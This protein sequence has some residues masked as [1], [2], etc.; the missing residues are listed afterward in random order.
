MNSSNNNKL[1]FILSLA[2][3]FMVTFAFANDRLFYMFCEAVG[4]SVS[5]NNETA[6]IK[7]EDIDESHF[8]KVLFTTETMRDVRVDFGV[9]KRSI[10]INLGKVYDNEYHFKNLTGDTL[11]FRPIHSVFPPSAANKYT[12]LKCFCFDDMVLYP[13]EELSLPMTF[14]FNTD[15]D[16]EINRIVMHY[17]LIKRE[18]DD[19]MIEMEDVSG[20]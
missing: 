7:P 16:P 13:H 18:R 15:V 8:V 2:V 9:A 14:F 6:V 17:Q 20:R 3:I 19:V 11:F 10:D 4:I 5:P 12:M 1:L